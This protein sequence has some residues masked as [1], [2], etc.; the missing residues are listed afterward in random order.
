MYSPRK[1]PG[2]ALETNKAIMTI[3]TI[4]VLALGMSACNSG[5]SSGDEPGDGSD[6]GGSTPETSFTKDNS[7]DVVKSVFQATQQKGEN[8][9]PTIP[10][11]G[12][13][14]SKQLYRD[15][16]AVSGNAAKQKTSTACGNGG[17]FSVT[18]IGDS[19][20]FK[21][22]N[23]L[24]VD[25]TTCQFDNDSST[26]D[27]FVKYT[28]SDV[29]G[30]P[31]NNESGDWSVTQNQDYDVTTTDHG[32]TDTAKGNFVLTTSYDK[33]SDQISFSYGYSTA[34]GGTI[35]FNAETPA[36][37]STASGTTTCS[38]ASTADYDSHSFDGTI[39]I[40]TIKK[41]K[42]ADGSFSQGEMTITDTSDEGGS[43][44][45]KVNGDGDLKIDVDTTGDGDFD[46]HYT[47]S[48]SDIFSAN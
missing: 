31:F 19:A 3:L 24:R 42:F 16:V 7:E 43:I 44:H 28:Y 27:G 36:D 37:C 10:S 38:F 11:G 34:D 40:E 5:G 22:G 48:F 25:Y 15:P 46:T 12:A 4:A 41:F 23:G 30:E 17:T 47:L 21:D 6:G 35:T 39:K 26:I 13:S 32:V 18:T 8:D 9:L 2:F 14:P 1:Q 20:G 45:I 29:K 33:S